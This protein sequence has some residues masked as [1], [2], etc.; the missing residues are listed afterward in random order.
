MF[1]IIV[2]L[3]SALQSARGEAPRT[4][5]YCDVFRRLMRLRIGR[6][7]EEVAAVAARADREE[8]RVEGSDQSSDESSDES[9][10]HWWHVREEE[11]NYAY[12]MRDRWYHRGEDVDPYADV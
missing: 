8:A 5:S 6:V 1:L 9:E 2:A 7:A 11:E 3:T 4:S 12:G 10:D